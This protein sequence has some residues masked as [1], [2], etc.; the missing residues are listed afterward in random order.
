MAF[1]PDPSLSGFAFTP[2]TRSWCLTSFR[3]ARSFVACAIGRRLLRNSPSPRQHW[4]SSL[5]SKLSRAST[6]T[7]ARTHRCLGIP[8]S[9]I[10][11][12]QRWLG[13]HG[14]G[15]FAREVLDGLEYVPI[16]LC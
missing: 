2:G 6:A 14:I 10:Y 5:L 1:S 12:D 16:P 11:A 3:L 13:N 9:M 15:R 4:R 7:R 8:T